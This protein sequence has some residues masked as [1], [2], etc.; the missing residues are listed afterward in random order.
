[1]TTAERLDALAGLTSAKRVVR[2]IVAGQT[3]VHAALLYGAPGSGKN[4]LAALL[5]EA[6][7]CR[8]PTEDG[9]DGTCRA[10]GAF[11]R[12]TNADYLRIAPAGPSRIIGVKAI[13]NESPDDDD[14]NPLITFFRTLPLMSRHKVAVIEDAERMNA[15]AA[16]ALLKTLEEP[17]PHAKLIL[18]TDSVGGILPTILSRCLAI[19]CETP[20]ADTL[21]R[22]YPEAT[23]AEV[24]MAEG[25]PGRLRHILTHREVY[26]RI[27]R[28]AST[29]LRHSPG[30]AL[31][32]TE[33]LRA[34]SA[35]L[36][37]AIGVNARA[38][39][40]ETLE[41]LAILL[42]R[43]PDAPPSWAQGIAEAHR[44]ILGNGSAGIVFDALLTRMLTETRA[45]SGRRS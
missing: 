24:R 19:A 4:A 42:A 30:E 43:D 12:G 44:R 25:T 11:S 10:C 22:M 34:I 39:N 33:E 32:A 13:T 38:A 15:A 28:Y 23:E 18:T 40:A 21:R 31:T 29:L 36:E 3:G 8:E 45:N 7:L 20:P 37:K 17:H 1:M 5:A 35:A 16:N 41:V 27:A 9:A 2:E 14:P 6:W 26:D